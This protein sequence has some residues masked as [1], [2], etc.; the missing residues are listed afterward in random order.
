MTKEALAE[1]RFS[2]ADQIA[3]AN[4]C[5]DWNPMHMS[6]IA[7]RRTLAGSPVVHG[8]HAMLWALDRI[9][10]STSLAGVVS[11]AARFDKFLLLDRDVQLR[12][13]KKSPELVKAELVQSGQSATQLTFKFGGRAP[14]TRTLSVATQPWTL[15]REP[16]TPSA[17][18]MAEC[19]GWMVAPSGSVSVRRAFPALVAAFGE[20]RVVDIALTSTLVGM[21]CPGLHSIY[22]EISIAVGD[23]DRPLSGLAWRTR[24]LDPRFGMV[25]MQVEG[26]GMGANITAFIRPAPIEQPGMASISD[27]HAMEFSNRRALIVG[28]SR[29]LGAATAMLLAKGG[30]EVVL[31]YSRG[32][33]DAERIVSEIRDDASAGKAI[34]LKFDATQDAEAQLGGV[35]PDL[36]HLY[37]F[38]TPQIF[39][40]RKEFSLE[41]FEEFQRFY[42]VG[43]NRLC[44]W[45]G[46]RQ[47]TA[48]VIIFNPS[49]SALNSRPKGMTEYTMAKASGEILAQDLSKT[50][51]FKLVM[52]RLPRILTDQTNSLISVEAA[53]AVDTM[54]PFLRAD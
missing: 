2:M 25:R 15:T 12:I 41:A 5:G 36:T 22:S 47:K 9:A 44:V 23:A 6:E 52:P 10:E 24:E 29:G 17:D 34:A 49:S 14:I 11:V 19:S 38:A 50:L 4:M 51:G 37:Y 30:A 45:L 35:P 54:L 13:S 46:H 27:V 33:S 43:F 28:G 16:H 53:N 26:A 3:F 40:Q 8:I 7:A 42:V 31:T 21:I 48:G 39:A 20:A 32:R 18:T 1:R